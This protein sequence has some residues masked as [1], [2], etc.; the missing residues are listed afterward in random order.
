MIYAISQMIAAVCFVNRNILR[1]CC[2]FSCWLA[3][4]TSDL[5][6]RLPEKFLFDAAKTIGLI[7]RIWPLLILEWSDNPQ[8]LLSTA[9]YDLLEVSENTERLVPLF[10]A[11]WKAAGKA[12]R[13]SLPLKIPS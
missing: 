6:D 2:V 10:A 4:L 3:K 1:S 7:G 9:I 8:R 12:G 11:R 5:T 13:W